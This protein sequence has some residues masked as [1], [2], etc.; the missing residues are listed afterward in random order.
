MSVVSRF[1]ATSEEAGAPSISRRRLLQ[2]STAWSLSS[3]VG[4]GALLS[5]CGSGDIV[6]ALVPSR[7]I[8]FGDGL[9]DVGQ[10]GSRYTIN[11][12]SVNTWADRLASR[13]GLTLKAQASGGLGYAQG[14]AVDQALPRSLSAQID[15][16]LASQTLGGSDVVLLNLPMADV[17]GPVAAVKAGTLS[18]AAALTQVDTSGRAHVVQVKRLLA[19]GAKFVVVLGLYD[20]GK[21]PFAI[22]QGQ[23]ALFT[24]AAQKLNDAFKTDAVSLGANLL[25]VDGAF[26]VNRN[27]LTGPSYGFVNINTAICTTASASACNSTTLLAGATASQYLWADGVHMTPS[28]NQQLGDYAYEQIRTRW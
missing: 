23:V 16:F 22:A 10:G 11:D 18:E 12:G 26:L 24:S 20:M 3:A 25:F 14:H 9:S 6:N 17:L 15:A 28:G 8:S 4:A 5:A 2:A 27:V 7:F 21:S 19:A 1:V 13:Y